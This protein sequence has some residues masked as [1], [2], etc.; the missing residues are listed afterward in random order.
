MPFTK[1]SE[2]REVF[3]TERNR[4][5]KENPDMPVTEVMVKTWKT[6]KVLAARAEYN[7]NKDAGKTVSDKKKPAKK[8]VKKTAK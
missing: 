5:A 8:A 4:L 2:V 1:W 7:K 3:K 6:P